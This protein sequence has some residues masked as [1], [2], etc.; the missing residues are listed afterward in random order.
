MSLLS[1]DITKVKRLSLRE[2]KLPIPEVRVEPI[3]PILV[4]R[5]PTDEEIAYS[6]LVAIN[7]LIE[8]LV[9]RLDLVS[10][11]TGE[12]IKKVELREEYKPHPE[13]EIKAQEI[14]RPKLIALA[15]R[16]IEGENSYNKEEIIERIKEATNVNQERAERG[17]NLILQ[18]GAI[19]QTINPGL[20][21]LV[22]STPF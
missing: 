19:E 15:Q 4:E 8:E 13:P 6:K 17:F 18:A 16:V 14:D 7:P 11:K 3:T 22:G 2:V 20:Y 10:I 5:P 12:R 21:Y 1:T 9:E